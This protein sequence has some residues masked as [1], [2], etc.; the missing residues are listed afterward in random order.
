MKN[1]F[2]LFIK[3]SL[4]IFFTFSNGY[5]EKNPN[6]SKTNP[7]VFKT[8]DSKNY[9]KLAKLLKSGINPCSVKITY[10]K[11][12]VLKEY[13]FGYAIFSGDI[14]VVKLFLPHIDNITKPTCLYN[15]SLFYAIFNDDIQMIQFLID[16]GA[17]VNFP[18]NL[19]M[20]ETPIQEALLRGKINSAQ[21]LID[22]GAII[23]KD[24]GFQSLQLAVKNLNIEVVK[25]LIDNKY[26]VN[27]QNEDGNTILHLMAMGIVEKNL[28]SIQ[29]YIEKK[30][31]IKRFPDTYVEAQ[32]QLNRLKEHFENYPKIANLLITSGAD[33]NLKN[34]D[35]KTPFIIASENNIN[36]MLEVLKNAK[37]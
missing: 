1:K 35:G 7:E 2:T 18:T 37:Q 14:N 33:T 22:N 6:L 12:A 31:Y 28:K 27:F 15:P 17:D 9:K 32:E 20:R 25:F 21:K 16:N 10:T 11:K 8:I 3:I 24:I 4:L 34:K 30:E 29:T 19:S 36:T 5:A 23:N 26:T 13:A